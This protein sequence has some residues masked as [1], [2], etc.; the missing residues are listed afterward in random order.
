MSG[1]LLHLEPSE[2][3]LHS[4]LGL[5]PSPATPED[6]V[7]KGIESSSWFDTLPPEVKDEVVD[8][9]LG[10]IAKNTKIL[11]LEADG[12]NNAEY[13]KLT[14][15]VA[16]SDAPHAQDIFVKY[17]STVNNADPEEELRQHFSRCRDSDR[18]I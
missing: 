5:L 2:A 13:F 7:A 14:T 6:N 1:R 9:A 12:G 3:Q 4:K 15:S 18:P 17:A 16:R 10:F 11:E 8:H